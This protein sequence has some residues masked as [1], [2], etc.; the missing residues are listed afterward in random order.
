[1]IR[2]TW[3]ATTAPPA[4]RCGWL[5]IFAL[6]RDRSRLRLADDTRGCYGRSTRTR[7]LSTSIVSYAYARWRGGLHDRRCGSADE[8]WTNRL[9]MQS[10]QAQLPG[11]RCSQH[12]TRSATPWWYHLV[13]HDHRVRRPDDLEG[14]TSLATVKSATRRAICNGR[15]PGHRS[16]HLHKPVGTGSH[17]V[18]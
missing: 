17:H 1:M 2:T 14:L 11:S 8:G 3:F 7:W 5:W 18:V 6:R 4:T 16:E 10:I 13:R 15:R 9:F 12:R